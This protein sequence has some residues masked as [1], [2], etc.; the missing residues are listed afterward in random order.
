[1]T[2]KTKCIQCKEGFFKGDI[3]NYKVLAIE[4]DSYISILKSYLEK[5]KDCINFFISNISFNDYTLD[6]SKIYSKQIDNNEKKKDN[7]IL[8][9]N[10]DYIVENYDVYS[11]NLEDEDLKYIIINDQICIS[12]S[13]N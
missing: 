1:M 10:I 3:W 11:F 8:Y 9:I 12:N 5:Y 2:I 7:D 4:T 6:K 13:F